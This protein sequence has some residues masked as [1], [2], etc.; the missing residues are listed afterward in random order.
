M[1][2]M[3]IPPN[4]IAAGLYQMDRKVIWNSVIQT[5]RV[6]NDVAEGRYFVTTFEEFRAVVEARRLYKKERQ[7][8]KKR[9]E[10]GE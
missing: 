10:R 3:L 6:M 4:Y 7:R 8:R 2:A 5:I 1:T 9:K